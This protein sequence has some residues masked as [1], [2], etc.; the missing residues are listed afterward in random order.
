M[1]HI[2]LVTLHVDEAFRRKGY[3]MKLMQ[4]YIALVKEKSKEE[5]VRFECHKDNI[6]ALNLYKKLGFLIDE[7]N[8][9]DDYQ[10]VLCILQIR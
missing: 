6:P 7:S 8:V 5:T 2:G 10:V 4:E 3:G 1:P 9:E